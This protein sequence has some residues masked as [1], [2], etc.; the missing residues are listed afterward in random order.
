MGAM[1]TSTLWAHIDEERAALADQLA[2]L[3]EEQWAMP[4]LCDDLSVRE[5]VAHLTVSGSLSGPRWFAGVLRARFD[6]DRQVADR[7]R[8]QLGA[9]SAET[10]AR[11]RATVGSRTSPPLPRVALLG[12][13]VVHGED[14]R[15]PLGLR[16]DHPAPV[17]EAV[18]RYYAGSNLM[19]PSRD[20]A[21]GVRLR[22]D[23]GAFVAG[24]GPEVRGSTLD[25]VMALTGR[26]DSLARLTGPGAGRFAAAL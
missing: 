14:V 4:S 12:E 21:R 25:L 10:L 16:H 2:G 6:F 3:T 5:V 22:A 7:L 23:D 9:T 24:D 20:R 26:R 15:R 1:G 13:V 8:E 19:L 18:A 17:L 11:F